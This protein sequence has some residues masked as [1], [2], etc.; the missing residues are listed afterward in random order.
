MDRQVEGALRLNIAGRSFTVNRYSLVGL[1]L[2]G[3]GVALLLVSFLAQGDIDRIGAT[4][5][6]ALQ[7]RVS[8]LEGERDTYL[9]AGFGS[10]FVGL[11]ALFTLVEK[12][13]ALIVSESQMMS[14]A[15][16]ASDVGA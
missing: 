10:F 4:E 3:L 13:V 14:R 8:V 12:T 7:E 11:F 5:D 2:V 16:S 15:E 9:I 6:P 1:I